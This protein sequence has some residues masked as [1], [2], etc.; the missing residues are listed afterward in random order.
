VALFW[1]AAI[2]N[3]LV[4]SFHRLLPTHSKPINV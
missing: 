4:L 1:A 3:R 2:F